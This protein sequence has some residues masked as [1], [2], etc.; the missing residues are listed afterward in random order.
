[1]RSDIDIGRRETLA[2]NVIAARKG[3]F[4]RVDDGFVG[5]IAD[6]RLALR[7]DDNPHHFVGRRGFDRSGGEKQPA[8]IGTSLPVAGRRRQTGIGKRI[9]QIGADCGGLGDDRIA[10]TQRRHLAHRIYREIGGRL[11]RRAVVENF[12]VIGPADL[13]EDPA[14]DPAARH[15]MGVEYEFIG[16]RT[17][18]N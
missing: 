10:V 14:H 15:R 3:A 13:F 18:L 2:D 4:K 5:A 7:R 1:M 16:H 8:I 17:F 6:H 12:G 9:G 11:H